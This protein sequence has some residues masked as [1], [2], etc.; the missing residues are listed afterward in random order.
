MTEH[1]GQSDP[2]DTLR[3]ALTEQQ[4]LLQTHESTLQALFEQQQNT[5]LQLEQMAGLLQR[6]LIGSPSTP[7]EEAN[8]SAFSQQTLRTRDVSSPNPEKF[9]GE[10]GSC[11]GFLLQCSLVFNRSPLSFPHDD[12]KISFIL[13]LLTGKAL[14]WAE[15]R[16]TDY[17]RFGCTFDEF[18]EEFKQTFSTN[19][20]QTGYSR[21]LWSLK[22]RNRPISEFS[23]EF[24]TL[25]ATSGWDSCAL[26]AAFFQALDE[27]LKDELAPRDEPKTLN[28]LILLATRLDNRIRERR[29][30]KMEGS[31]VRFLPLPAASTPTQ[32]VSSLPGPEPE[33]M[34][35]GQTR[36]TPEERQRRRDS[37]QCI[38]CGSPDHFIASCPIRPKERVHRL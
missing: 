3:K 15:A 1:S 14:R 9:S 17:S 21:R 26:K 23:I 4:Q 28:E 38:Y 20:D 5:N 36:L 34:Q 2:A 37:K 12:A 33:P 25:A 22:Q 24:R 8:S 19:T 29:R 10:V 18:I 6:T 35:I 16:F 13:G 30:S 32:S 31:T 7:S 11:G 27:S